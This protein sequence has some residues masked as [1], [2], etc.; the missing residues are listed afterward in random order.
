MIFSN[1]KGFTLRKLATLPCS[2]LQPSQINNPL[3]QEIIQKSKQVREYFNIKEENACKHCPLKS[4]CSLKFKKYSE[5]TPSPSELKN[6]SVQDLN[7]L[8]LAGY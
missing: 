7:F 1:F 2:T 4:Q 5:I 6:I 3:N 8:H